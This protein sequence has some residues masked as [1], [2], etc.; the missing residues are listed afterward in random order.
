MSPTIKHIII[1]QNFWTPKQIAV[2]IQ[3]LNCVCVYNSKLCLEDAY[4]MS[5]SE[6]PDQT[7][8]LGAV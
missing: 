8:P 5:N 2:I 3:N 1:F 7:A 6:D 4:R